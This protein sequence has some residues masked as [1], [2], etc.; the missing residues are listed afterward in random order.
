M[1]QAIGASTK[2]TN[3]ELIS[4]AL[5]NEVKIL[6]EHQATAIGGNTTNICNVD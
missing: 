6:I 1:S 3:S 2:Y 5:W 4:L